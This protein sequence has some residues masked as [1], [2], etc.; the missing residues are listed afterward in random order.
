M[1]R[2]PRN[3]RGVSRRQVLRSG[4]A[5]LGGRAALLAGASSLITKRYTLA[6]SRQ[7]VQDYRRSHDHHGR[8]RVRV[9]DNPV[10]ASIQRADSAATRS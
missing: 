4:A 10:L 1:A 3:R 2:H 5:A 6:D 7:A 9:G 8:D